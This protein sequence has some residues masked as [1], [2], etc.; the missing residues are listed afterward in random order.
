[1]RK[2][3]NFVKNSRGDALVTSLV[4][5]AVIGIILMGIATTLEQYTK[6]SEKTNRVLT[7]ESLYKSVIT[8]IENDESWKMT[9][10]NNPA[11][12]CL[13][14]TGAVCPAGSLKFNVYLQNGNLLAQGDPAGGNGFDNF[15]NACTGFSTA[16]PN[17]NCPYAYDISASADCVGACPSTVLSITN[18]VAIVPKVNIR[19]AILFSGVT[20]VGMLNMQRYTST[21]VRGQQVGTLAANCRALYGNFDT[22]T[23]KCILQASSCPPGQLFYGFDNVGLALCRENGFLDRSCGSGFA[24]MKVKEGGGYECSKF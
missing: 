24:P 23:Q 12:S 1:M 9:V 15:G 14:A 22:Q 10:T 8:T 13:R 21:F 5:V 6:G 18:Q 16:V 3:F 20:N 11:M 4:V 2:I 7:L 19:V 17:D